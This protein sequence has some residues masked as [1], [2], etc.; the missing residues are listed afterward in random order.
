MQCKNISI[1]IF[2]SCEEISITVKIFSTLMY[3]CLTDY[4]IINQLYLYRGSKVKAGKIII[5]L[6]NLYCCLFGSFSSVGAPA[7]RVVLIDLKSLVWT[8]WRSRKDSVFTCL[9]LHFSVMFVPQ[10]FI[11]RALFPINNTAWYHFSQKLKSISYHL[12]CSAVFSS[13]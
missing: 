11:P 3:V 5:F 9:V 10:V 1:C 6:C 2:I 12:I 13:L 4:L 7:H 8:S